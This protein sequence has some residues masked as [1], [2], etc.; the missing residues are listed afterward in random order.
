MA[1]LSTPVTY[2]DLT[3]AQKEHIKKI[4]VL[5]AQARFNKRTTKYNHKKSTGY[6]QSEAFGF[7]RRRNRVPGPSRN[8]DRFPE[9]W[10]ALQE[11]GAIIPISYD[12]VQVNKNC[13]CNPH[14]DEGNVGN[15]L[16]VSGNLNGTEYEGGELVTEYGT[17]NA[18][19]RGVIFDGAKITHS[20]A[21]ITVGEKWSLVFFSVMIPP[22]I[23]AKPY[24]TDGFR[25]LHPYYR[26]RFL[27]IIPVQETKYYP[28]G[29]VRKKKPE[30]IKE[31]VL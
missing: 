17:Y 30:T 21:P 20:N 7:I 12:A 14:K 23:L 9:L 18:K 26:N 4:E 15:S 28:N 3:E 13:V 24:F 6:G 11:L 31:N 19:Y 22:H 16:L 29:I 25:S 1:C 27:D 8:N 2:Y 5:I 10:K